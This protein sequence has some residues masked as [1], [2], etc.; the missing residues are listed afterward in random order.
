MHSLVFIKISQWNNNKVS[1]YL[2]VSTT[3]LNL[4]IHQI[5]HQGSQHNPT[6]NI[7]K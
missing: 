4:K 3:H 6:G 5:K 2:K 7:E 1:K